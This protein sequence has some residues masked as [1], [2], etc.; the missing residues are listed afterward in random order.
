MEPQTSDEHG[1]LHLRTA[2]VGFIGT[3]KSSLFGAGN[4]FACY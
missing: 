4:V 1:L 3:L 2:K